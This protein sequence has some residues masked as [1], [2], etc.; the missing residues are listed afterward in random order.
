MLD[1]VT[2]V[3]DGGAAVRRVVEC[4]PGVSEAVKGVT[5]AV[6]LTAKLRGL[7]VRLWADSVLRVT[8]SLTKYARGDNIQNLTLAGVEWVV[9]DLA[10]ALHLDPATAR[11]FRLDVGCTFRMPR[12]PVMYL[13][14]L[15][16]APRYRRAEYEDET[17]LFLAGKARKTGQAQRVLSFYDKARQASVEDENLLR[18]EMQLRRRLKRQIG[19]ALTLADLCDPDTFGQLVQRW[20]EEYECVHKA[21]RH[22]LQSTGSTRELEKQLAM[23]G[24]ECMGAQSARNQLSTWRAEGTVRNR[25]YHRLKRRV[26]ELATSGAA[27]E[28]REVIEEL[29][30]AVERAERRALSTE[31]RT[32]KVDLH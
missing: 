15:V 6:R 19:Q 27:E 9:E 8:G 3:T 11:V 7:H 17:V 12:S 26:R 21:R 10:T 30:R 5:G 24:L 25:Q 18:Y 16:S 1:T 20:R 31:A 4:L 29:S 28:D 13:D 32:F 22:V 2:I 14:R 23:V